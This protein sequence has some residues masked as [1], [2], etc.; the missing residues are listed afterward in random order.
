MAKYRVTIEMDAEGIMKNEFI[1]S[2]L[3]MYYKDWNH[4]VVYI[5]DVEE[6]IDNKR[7]EL[8][9]LRSRAA[10]LGWDKHRRFEEQQLQHDIEELELKLMEEE[11]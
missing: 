4:H 6:A 3:N 10:I 11:E 2:L 7:K 1:E 8:T 9:S 5:S